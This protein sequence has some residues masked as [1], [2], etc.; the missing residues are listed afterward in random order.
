MVLVRQL[1]VQHTETRLLR[2]SRWTPS[3]G[4][5]HPAVLGLSSSPISVFSFPKQALE[6]AES[7]PQ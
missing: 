7:S 2:D 3:L 1:A 4:K 6:V 5:T